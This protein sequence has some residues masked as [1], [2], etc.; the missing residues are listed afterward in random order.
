[1]NKSPSTL[2][3]RKIHLQL[4][5][6]RCLKINVLTSMETNINLVLFWHHAAIALCK[7]WFICLS[8]DNK[9]VPDIL[10]PIQTV[11]RIKSYLFGT[12]QFLIN[13][14]SIAMEQS[15]NQILLLRPS[16]WK[17]IAALLSHPFVEFFQVNKNWR[18]LDIY[19]FI[20]LHL[21]Q[22][23]FL[24]KK[25]LTDDTAH[26][27]TKPSTANSWSPQPRVWSP[28]LWVWRLQPWVW[29]PQPWKWSA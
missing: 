13:V 19:S 17:M 24:K 12:P 22:I 28:K 27:C 29:R 16:L 10:A 5:Q 18:T 26:G 23:L 11:I 14:V 25:I 8:I 1:M 7:F 9:F 4:M 21:T 2:V 15:S 6:M 20:I 3:L